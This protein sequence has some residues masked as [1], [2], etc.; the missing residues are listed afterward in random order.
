MTASTFHV[1]EAVETIGRA[2]AY[3]MPLRRR[4]EGVTWMVWGLATA[5]AFLAFSTLDPTRY[6]SWLPMIV[7]WPMLGIVGSAA[8]WRIAALS[9]A[10]L[11]PQASRTSGTMLI[12]MIGLALALV[13]SLAITGGQGPSPFLLMSAITA[14]PWGAFGM[15]QWR[16]MT[17]GG[18]RTMVWT[19]AAM[20]MAMFVALQFFIVQD[21]EHTPTNMLVAVA[22]MGGLPFA[23]GL[24]RAFRG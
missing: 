21:S 1:H 4:T 17:P 13:T 7:L 15:L 3:D 12:I 22:V 2:T 20:V 5:V 18:Q 19:G 11:A 16:R 9:R 14:I 24:W 23:L 10:T 8:A 6:V